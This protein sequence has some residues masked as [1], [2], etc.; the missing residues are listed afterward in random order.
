[1]SDPIEINVSAAAAT[2]GPVYP[3]EASR[4]MIDAGV[5]YGRKK[6][7][8]NPKMRPFILANRGGI[9][10]INLQKTMEMMDAAAGFIKEKIRQNALVL[11][12]G[13]E[14]GAEPVITRLAKKYNF[15][16]VTFRWVGGAITNFKI[17]SKRIE[18]LKKLRT[19]LASGALVNKYTKKERLELE[20][21]MNRLEELMGGLE[22]LT[23][24]PDLLIMV[25]PELHKTALREARRK[26][27]PVVALANVDADPDEIDYLVPGNDK[28]KKSI[29]WFFEHVEKAIDEGLAMRAAA[30][31]PTP[32]APAAP[33][34]PAVK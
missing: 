12:V 23:R 30:P 5:F 26:K 10:V 3:A 28:A 4:E 7:K 24:E 33:I 2:Q 6:S 11:L 29:D 15:P 25:D 34:A 13:V 8:T 32:T 21:E 20:R 1:M 17:I 16:Y 14:P 27:I 19:D 18:Y 22:N 9:E 31:A